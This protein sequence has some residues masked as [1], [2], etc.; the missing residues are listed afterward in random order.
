[1]SAKSSKEPKYVS[2]GLQ[3][4]QLDTEREGLFAF[5]METHAGQ[6]PGIKTI[7][8][9]VPN[10]SGQGDV[11]KP[12]YATRYINKSLQFSGLPQAEL[13]KPAI[14]H[15]SEPRKPGLSVVKPDEPADEE[16]ESNIPSRREQGTPK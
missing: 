2:L 15:F 14:P 8:L 16:A 6:E 5:T 10:I 7:A 1:M 11:S 3:W 13:P 9:T 4:V 12:L